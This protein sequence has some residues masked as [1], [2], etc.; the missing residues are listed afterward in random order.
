M[1]DI[2]LSKDA[3]KTLCLIYK[4]YLSRRKNNLSKSSSSCFE[5]SS[6][7]KLFPDVNMEDFFCDLSELKKNNLIEL[8]LEGSFI[9]NSNAIIY[10]ENRFKK[11]LIEV[12]DFIAKF[13][14]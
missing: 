12:T 9:L 2:I 11:G 5:S 10:M 6:L 1:S 3:D 4:E 7:E 14:P 13:I 8:Y